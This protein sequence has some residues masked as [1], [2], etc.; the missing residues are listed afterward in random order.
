ML[1]KFFFLYSFIKKGCHVDILTFLGYALFTFL[2]ILVV[3]H[4]CAAKQ[5]MPHTPQKKLQ[6]V[7]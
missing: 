5:L 4:R 2:V 1:E 6:I 7:R 3:S